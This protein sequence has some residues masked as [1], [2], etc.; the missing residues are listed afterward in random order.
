MSWRLMQ[1]KMYV[2][3]SFGIALVLAVASGANAGIWGHWP[4]NDGQ[5]EDAVDLGPRSETGF[6][7]NYDIGGLNDDFGVWYDDPDR[8][9]V[10]SFNGEADGAYV[11]AG[12]MPD[13]LTT[14][15]DSDF[16][17]S[18]WARQDELQASPSNDIIL[19]NR[20]AY[21]GADTSPR[22]FVKFTANRF[23][24]HMNAGG[25]VE[26]NADGTDSF[27]DDLQ[28]LDCDFCPERHIS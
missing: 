11:F 23:E 25:A 13:I 8:G 14:D 9:M 7:G 20:H 12:F 16:T 19:G 4:L 3:S 28:Y 6:V 21:N 24:Y 27:I 17:W 18:F 22:E 15:D 2:L 26:T 10:A 1:Q 5:G